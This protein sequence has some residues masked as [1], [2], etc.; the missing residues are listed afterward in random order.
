MTS[1]TPQGAAAVV[2]PVAT[3]PVAATPVTD[4]KDEADKTAPVIGDKK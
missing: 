2:L 4:K 1:S 3:T